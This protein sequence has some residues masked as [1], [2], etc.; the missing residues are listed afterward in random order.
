MMYVS[1]VTSFAPLCEPTVRPPPVM[2]ICVSGRVGGGGGAG[3]D[4][5]GAGGGGGVVYRSGLDC[6]RCGAALWGTKS[7]ACAFA[8]VSNALSLSVRT[9]QKKYYEHWRVC[10]DASC[11]LRTQATRVGAPE[12]CPARGCRGKLVDE[13]LKNSTT[14]S[15]G[16][17]L[18]DGAW[19]ATGAVGAAP[20]ALRHRGRRLGSPLCGLERVVSERPPRGACRVAGKGPVSEQLLHR[21]C[22]RGAVVALPH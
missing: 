5:G 15:L 3:G 1:E 2:M 8:R 9:A 21:F 20:A 17:S 16:V 14:S 10:D 7:P 13:R 6:P 19:R 11:A 4:A 22:C 12:R 18:V